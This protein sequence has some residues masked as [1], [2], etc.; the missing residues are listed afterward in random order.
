MTYFTAK[1]TFEVEHCCNCGMAFAITL[2][3]KNRKQK[4]HSNFYCPNGHSQHYTGKSQE[5]KLKEELE[6]KQQM[7]DAANARAHEQEEAKKQIA[8]AHKKM[9]VRVMSGACPCCNRTF[10][11]LMNHMKS[12]HPDFVEK[13][14]LLTLRTA[15]GMSQSQL[16]KEM[17]TK[18]S[19]ISNYER[20]IYVPEYAKVLIESWVDKHQGNL[21]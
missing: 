2:T 19:Y 18:P 17:S 5:Q 3:F 9:R 13:S 21:V 6:R 20:N 1:E 7:L 8:I 11:N 14:T 10:Q 15:F 4:D 12:E 16:A